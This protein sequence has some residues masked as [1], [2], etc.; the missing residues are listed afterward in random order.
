MELMRIKNL[1]VGE[2]IRGFT[3]HV[4]RQRQYEYY[5]DESG[6]KDKNE[7][8]DKASTT[9][10]VKDLNTRD[11]CYVDNWTGSKDFVTRT[12]QNMSTTKKTE[13]NV[14][15][16]WD[17]QPVDKNS[18]VDIEF[19]DGEFMK[20]IGN[21]YE[22]SPRR[23]ELSIIIPSQLPNN[24]MFDDETIKGKKHAGIQ[25]MMMRSLVHLKHL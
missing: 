11:Y 7:S 24:A 17:W 14:L 3:R 19:V 8:V 6:G 5:N 1:I 25:L 22:G 12:L 9:D 13:P 2:C 18:L 21:G 4:S 16:Y 20:I 10:K 23:M 15:F